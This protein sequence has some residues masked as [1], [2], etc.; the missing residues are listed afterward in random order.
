MKELQKYRQLHRDKF[1]VDPVVIGLFWEAPG[2]FLKHLR[3]AVENNHVYN[4]LDFLSEDE[5]QDYRMGRLYF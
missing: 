3:E 5:L 1:G 2:L 4:E